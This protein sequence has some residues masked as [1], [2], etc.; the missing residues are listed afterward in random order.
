M[1]AE[2]NEADEVRISGVK[3]K[4]RGDIVFVDRINGWNNTTLPLQQRDKQGQV[5]ISNALSL[6]GGRHSRERA[7]K[8]EIPV[9]MG[10]L[11]NA[12]AR[13]E[14]SKGA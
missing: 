2:G 11:N 9:N 4:H 6:V 8:C 10:V 3:S 14:D 7:A 13:R 1:K 5:G 12:Q